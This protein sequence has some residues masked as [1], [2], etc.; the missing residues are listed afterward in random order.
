MINVGAGSG[1]CPHPC[2]VQGCSH[3]AVTNGAAQVPN[4]ST[5]VAFGTVW[6]LSSLFIQSEPEQKPRAAEANL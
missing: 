5:S 3:S 6:L 4:C 1:S 2:C